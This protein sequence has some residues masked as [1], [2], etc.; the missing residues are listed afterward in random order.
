[1]YYKVYEQI[2]SKI[3]VIPEIAIVLGSGLGDFASK[4]DID[5]I[6]PY[7]ELDGMPVST[8][9]SHKGQFVFGKIGERNVVIMQGRIHLYEG[10][11]PQEI[12]VPIRALKLLG[13]KKIILT[14][15][16]GAINKTY[17]I[18]DFM[19][20]CD[21]ISSFVTS[22]LVGKNDD[23]IGP[24]F[25]D[26]TNAYSPILKDKIIEASKELGIELKQGVLVQTLGPQFETPA[27]IKMY[28]ILGA[29][30]VGMSTAIDA[31]IARHCG[32]EV[33]G[34]S[35]VTNMAA[36]IENIELSG[37]DVTLATERCADK[38]YKLLKKAVEVI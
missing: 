28:S 4:I 27:E 24:R 34:I 31:I 33:C 29:D 11:A 35:F 21:H 10:Y 5:T 1:M 37:E 13:V 25:K 18:G 20:I 17:K 32:I 36:G 23:S 30:V 9:P 22:P 14:N 12:A 2:K 3:S 15:A 6:I 7:S 16:V 8:A 19:L 38:F 26:M